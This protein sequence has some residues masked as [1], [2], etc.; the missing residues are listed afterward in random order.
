MK[1]LK[2]LISVVLSVVMVASFLVVGTSAASYPDVEETASYS[3][4][5]ELLSALDI[6]KGDENGNFNP[7]AEIKRSEFAAV[8]CRA[9]GQENAATSSVS[10][11]D[12]VAANHWAVGYIGWAAGKGIVNGYGDGTF[13]PD[14]AVSYQEA[15]KMIMAAL[16]YGKLAENKGGYPYG[17]LSL[18]GTYGVTA[19][20]SANPTEA[21]PRS[22]VAQ[23]VYNALEAPLMD[24]SYYSTTE[25]RYVV[26]DG[27]KA[28]DYE[29]RTILSQ[30]LD[31]IKVRAKVVANYKTDSSLWK[32]NG[33]PMVKVDFLKAYNESD[34]DYEEIG[35]STN[36]GYVYKTGIKVF[37]GETDAADF[38]AQT[39]DAYLF[40]NEDEALELKAIISDGKSIETL[41]V[42]K[43]IETATVVASPSAAP[44]VTFEYWEDI[45]NDAKPE[46]VD[47]ATT[48]TVYLNGENAG[49]ITGAGKDEFEALDDANFAGKVTFVGARGEAFS[50]V[51]IVKYEY[52]QVEKIDLEDEY[53][54]FDHDDLELSKKA[55]SDTFVYSIYKDGEE[56]A[57]EDVKVG[58]V[59]SLVRATNSVEIYVSS[60]TL[61]GMVTGAKSSAASNHK[62]DID[63]VEYVTVDANLLSVGDA[64]TFYLTADGKI[65]SAEATSTVSDN[66]GFILKVGSTSSFQENTYQMRIFTKEGTIATYTIAPTLKV[67]E[68]TNVA[69]SA[70]PSATPAPAQYKYVEKSYKRT[71]NGQASIMARLADT[72]ALATDEPANPSASPAPKTGADLAYEALEERLITYT[73]DGDMITK[74]TIASNIPTGAALDKAY[75]VKDFNSAAYKPATDKFANYIYTDA[76][77]LFYAPIEE[78]ETGKWGVDE[79]K[80]ALISVSSLDEEKTD[81]KGYTYA[82][83]SDKEFGAAV[84]TSDLGFAGKASALAVVIG[85][86]DGLDDNGEKAERLTV[87]RGGEVASYVI[88]DDADFAAKD[89][90]VAGDIIQFV[91]NGVDEITA[92]EL[93]F[94]AND[95]YNGALAVATPDPGEEIQYLFGIVKDVTSKYITLGDRYSEIDYAVSFEEGRTLAKVELAKIDRAPQSAIQEAPS[96]SSFRATKDSY[97]D[98]YVMVVRVVDE[99]IV[100][101]VSYQIDVDNVDTD[102]NG[103]E[104]LGG[105]YTIALQ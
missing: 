89:S 103:S 12:D 70:A 97:T 56:I 4:A 39:V 45:D 20:L 34:K 36:V 53:L 27:S 15:V 58:D 63:G 50:D 68:W 48:A 102:T 28:A 101:A 71:G 96:V 100:D 72:T 13:G 91:L 88:N 38:L 5:V 95:G 60:E 99:E 25:E 46:E 65:Y 98:Q 16:G 67:S 85:K 29:E 24:T 32:K 84:I 93:I 57:L 104:L 9:L 7:D 66:Y 22:L 3:A 26:Y 69:P 105:S 41:E 44:V 18:A 75:A 30:Y 6:L 19:G 2:K 77:K 14:K 37:E 51:F 79:D 81:Y 87:L 74:I 11:F 52:A 76:T 86:A 92:A 90:I 21:A 40:Y 31:I 8:V 35:T 80:V 23:L 47:V 94:D 1:N 61:T 73:L 10:K 42:A 33:R 43:D 17:Y 78:V 55:N 54:E 59:L 64:G 82:M 49:V 62:Y 83:N